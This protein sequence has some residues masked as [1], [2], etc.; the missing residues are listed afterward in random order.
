[1][2]TL[3]AIEVHG[4]AIRQIPR[5]IV[6]CYS[7]TK[8]K[9]E[10]EI[11]ETECTALNFGPWVENHKDDVELMQHYRI[12]YENRKI[13]RLLTLE[14]KTP[15][16]AGFWMVQPSRDTSSMMRW[17]KKQ[18]FLAPTLAESVQLYLASLDN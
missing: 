5:E 1:M 10:N 6:S 17:D 4:L 3:T 14:T 7:I 16:N 15:E 8:H 18:H 11:V 12:D 2:D 9:P 13:Y